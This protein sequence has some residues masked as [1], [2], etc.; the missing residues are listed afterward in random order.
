MFQS[1]KSISD[2]AKERGVTE[3]T[4]ENHLARF[5]ASGEDSLEQI[6]P[7]QKIEPIRQ[8][9]IKFADTNALS[10]IKEFLGDEYRYG[11]IKA[12]IASMGGQF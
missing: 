1:G 8:A 4:V 9:I 6:V 3:N 12:V 5:I 10:P 11:E 7:D 2:I